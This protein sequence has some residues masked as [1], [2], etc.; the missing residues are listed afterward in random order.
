MGYNGMQGFP[1]VAS[2]PMRQ[3][4]MG[5]SPVMPPMGGGPV[6][7]G[8]HGPNGMNPVDV[9]S[10]EP[11]WKALCDF[12]LHSDLDRLN[13]NTP[14]YQNLVNQVSEKTILL[15]ISILYLYYASVL[16]CI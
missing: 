12:A 3:D 14:N 4:A 16:P 6:G 7:G 10:Y 13:P 9:H 15:H 11:P 8:P 1:M 5:N 2:S